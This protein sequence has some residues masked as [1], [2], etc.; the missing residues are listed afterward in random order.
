MKLKRTDSALTTLKRGADP[1]SSE[2]RA[3][4]GSHDHRV[5]SPPGNRS[6]GTGGSDKEPS[7]TDSLANDSRS[8][9]RGDQKNP[10]SC[11][12]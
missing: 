11:K 6:Q 1:E 12:G 4:G 10:S 2:D 9:F 8:P 3:A 5:K 7:H